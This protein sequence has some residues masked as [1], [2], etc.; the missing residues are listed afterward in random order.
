MRRFVIS[1]LTFGVLEVGY[2]Q[3]RV[4]ENCAVE[5]IVDVADGGGVSRAT[6]ELIDSRGSV[7]QTTGVSSGRGWFCD[8][9]FGPHSIR[10]ERPGSLPVTLAGIELVYGET[11][12]LRVILNPVAAQEKQVSGGNACRAYVRVESVEGKSVGGASATYRG[13]DFSADEYGRVL[14]LVPMNTLAE[15]RFRAVGF[16][17]ESVSLSCSRPG[18][19]REKAVILSRESR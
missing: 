1:L 17:A 15:F 9:G 19:V 10:V 12:R 18:E 3:V 7:I 8:F 14:L 11:Q 13:R 5:V 4:P 2:S 6:A 16:R